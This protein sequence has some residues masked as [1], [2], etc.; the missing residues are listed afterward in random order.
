MV[1]QNRLFEMTTA[2]EIVQ[3][4][5]IGVSD[6]TPPSQTEPAKDVAIGPGGAIHVGHGFSPLE[7]GFLHTFNA[8]TGG[9]RHDTLSDWNF[10][11]PKGIAAVGDYVFLTGGLILD[12]IVRF[13]TSDDYSATRFAEGLTYQDLNLGRCAADRP[14]CSANSSTWSGPG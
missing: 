1:L 10:S 7:E 6:G 13:D 9:W 11:T 3:V 5:P 8:A 2:G 14:S 12:G 4:V